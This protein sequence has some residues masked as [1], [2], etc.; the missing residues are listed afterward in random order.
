MKIYPI[1]CAKEVVI[2]TAMMNTKKVNFK[3]EPEVT[4]ALSQKNIPPRKK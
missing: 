2:V 1:V 3:K 4:S